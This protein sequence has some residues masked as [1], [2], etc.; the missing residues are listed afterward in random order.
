MARESEF[1]IPSLL[2]NSVPP[3]HLHR[4][5]CQD[6][7]FGI[8]VQLW[9]RKSGK[10]ASYSSAGG[11][12]ARGGEGDS[13][14][15]CGGGEGAAE[16]KAPQALHKVGDGR[17]VLLQQRFCILPVGLL[18]AKPKSEINFKYWFGVIEELLEILCVANSVNKESTS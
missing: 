13:A 1:A 9:F 14:S 3:F 12:G 4:Q 7:P 2:A 10:T 6:T 8:L 15:R 5:W 11:E 16:V 17:L 18:Q